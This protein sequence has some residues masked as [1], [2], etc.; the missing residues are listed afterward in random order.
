M[1][2]KMFSQIFD[3]SI[4][5]DYQVRH[6]FEDLCKLA[7][8]D[9]VVDMTPE[10]ISART[11]IPLD[12]VKPALTKLEAPD[13]R[14]RSPNEEGRRIVLIDS[15]RDW[16]W[17]IV[18]YQHYRELRDDD[19][20]RSYFRDYMREYRAKKKGINVL[21]SKQMLN[22]VNRRKPPSTHAEAEAEALLSTD[23]VPKA[24]IK[25]EKPTIE[26]VKLQLAKVGL[27]ESESEGFMAY[28]ESNGWKVGRNPM[29]SW[30]GA[31]TTWKRNY[32]QRRTKSTIKA[33]PA[34]PRTR[35]ENPRNFGV[36]KSTT[37]YAAS[38]KYATAQMVRKMAEADAQRDAAKQIHPP[39]NQP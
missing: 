1:F 20:R 6:I 18:N 36:C 30:V 5:D 21:N 19:A 14:S 7:D 10:A 13:S 4:A 35:E 22:G 27:P 15:H 9:G 12:I 37:D 17:R 33:N 11:R 8:V 38:S 39:T 3:S 2:A 25:F 26:A 29:K 28:Y 34:Y 32:E 23:L 16:G 24:H 31:V